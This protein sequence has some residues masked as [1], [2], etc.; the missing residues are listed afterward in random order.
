MRTRKSFQ[1]HESAHP[2]N[3]IPADNSMTARRSEAMLAGQNR[4]LEMVAQGESLA[5]ILDA[6]CKLVEELS[7]DCLCSI[8]LLDA[9]GKRFSRGAAPG[10]PEIYVETIKSLDIA[11]CWGPCAKA[12]Y[13]GE[14]VIASE[15]KADQQWAGCCDLLLTIGLRACW[16]T[17]IFSSGREVLGAFA[18]FWHEPRMPTLDDQNAIEQFTHLASIAIEQK[19]S[20]EALLVSEQLARGQFAALASTLDA[21][22]ME[23]APD[24]LVEHVLRIIT[25]QLGA[26][27]SSVWHRNETSGLIGFEF[28]YENGRLVTKSDAIVGAINPSF[29]TK[30]IW[31]WPEVFRTSKPYLLEDI[32]QGPVFPW[33]DHLL[34]VGVLTMLMVPMLIAG[35]IRGAMCIHFTRKRTFRE[36][37][38]ELARALANQATLAMQLTR[39][40]AQSREAAVVAERNRMARDIH[41]TLAQ[42]FTGVIVQLEAAADATSKGLKRESGGHLNRARELARDSLNEARRSVLALRPHA[43]ENENLAEA[44]KTFIQKMTRGTKIR[45]EFL[46]VGKPRELPE[47]WDENLLHIGREALTNALRH[48]AATEFNAKLVFETAAVYLELRDNGKGFDM[49]AHNNGF[50]LLGMKERVKGMGGELI[51]KSASGRGT[52]ISIFLPN[53]KKSKLHMS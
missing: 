29:R 44:L 8:L 10:I 3:A 37:E 11:T 38:M 1:S 53:A 51:I 36:E 27:S 14:Q 6:T 16:S 20:V 25:E 22:A 50:G 5:L 9:D 2:L 41:D 32:C 48:A 34:E 35:Q 21:L 47:K 24:R 45:A 7:G 26:H 40:S 52:A 13:F 30:Y 4:L 19:K 33:R 49:A 31:P 23:S 43:L 39:L 15:I 42:G 17:P 12:A 18:V 46:L 28:I